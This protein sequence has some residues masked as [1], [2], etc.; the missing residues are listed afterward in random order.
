M[1]ID[2]FGSAKTSSRS[3]LPAA[4]LTA[5][6]LQD[7]EKMAPFGPGNKKPLLLSRSLRLRGAPKKRG[8]D[9]LQCWMTDEA[10]K[11]TCEVIGFRAYERWMAD[12]PKASVDI[13][14]QPVLKEWRGL[15]SIEL[16]LEDWR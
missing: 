12:G 6:L 16:Q 2:P 15:T 10:G 11:M 5:G 7:L 1:R 13:V 3:L 8:K 4:L 9:T 14:Y